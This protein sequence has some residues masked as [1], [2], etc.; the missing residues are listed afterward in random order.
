MKWSMGRGILSAAAD[1]GVWGSVSSS[2]SGVRAENGY[3]RILK[4][5]ERSFFTYMTK[6]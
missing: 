4:A 5:T 6:I 3:R 1:Y 2:G